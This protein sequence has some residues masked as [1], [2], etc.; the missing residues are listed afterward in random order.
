MRRGE[1][2]RFSLHT[3]G[4]CFH[5][6]PSQTPS[7]SFLP[8]LSFL[9]VSLTHCLSLKR[10][11]LLSRLVGV[12]DG[13]R[14]NRLCKEGRK[15]NVTGRR[16]VSHFLDLNPCQGFRHETKETFVQHDHFRRN[17]SSF[18]VTSVDSQIACER[19]QQRKQDHRKEGEKQES[20]FIRRRKVS[21][22]TVYI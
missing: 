4:E 12:F 14:R 9:S 11:F 19:V 15:C 16:T 6:H 18:P 8:S 10:P 22:L 2:K 3:H 5:F 17:R 21:P 20:S 1:E 13:S 7:S